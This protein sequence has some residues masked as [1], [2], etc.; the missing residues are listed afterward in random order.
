MIRRILILTL[1]LM[2]LATLAQAQS[3]RSAGK[4]Y[5]RE[6]A[7]DFSFQT[8]YT[9]S[10]DFDGEGGSSVK[11]N[12]SMGW[13]FGFNYNISDNFDLGFS[14]NWRTM[15]YD[16]T[17]IE[18]GTGTPSTYGGSINTSTIGAT[19]NWNIIA[20][21]ITPYVSGSI[22]WTILDS[23]IFA[24]WGTGCW[25][26]YWWGY[27]CGSVPMTYGTDAASYN[28]GV[29]GRFE[30]SRSFF[31]RAGYEYNW[32]SLDSFDAGSMIRIDL[33]LMN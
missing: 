2:S 21:P 1:I 10:Q 16:A 6:G 9:A 23:N 7:W 28:L 14:F 18:E 33:G 17:A 20:G 22:G 5:Y 8:R 15:N 11:L 27:I 31:I 29:G 25:Y 30:L 32:M 26:D 13:G 12:D 24:G 4:A 3:Q 19:G